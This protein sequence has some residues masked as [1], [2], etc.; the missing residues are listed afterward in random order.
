MGKIAW[1]ITRPA[2]SDDQ[3]FGLMMAWAGSVMAYLAAVFA[4]SSPESF[5][6]WG[7]LA[8][9]QPQLDLGEPGGGLWVDEPHR[10]VAAGVIYFGLLC[11]GKLL[12]ALVAARRKR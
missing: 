12:A 11:T 2:T 6:R 3:M 9:L 5:P 10:V 4:T 1:V 8:E 7:I